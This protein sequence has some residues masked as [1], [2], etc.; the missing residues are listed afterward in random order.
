VLAR[1]KVY[2]TL[3]QRLDLA[4]VSAS[5]RDEIRAQIVSELLAGECEFSI[6]VRRVVIR[7]LEERS[8]QVQ[9]RIIESRFIY[10]SLK[11]DLKMLNPI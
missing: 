6:M 11:N 10:E 8:R 5:Q 7:W 1:R 9:R 2:N 4:Q 3:Q